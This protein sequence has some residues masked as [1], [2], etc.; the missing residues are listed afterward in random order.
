MSLRKKLIRLAHSQPELRKDL[1]PLLKQSGINNRTIIW[2]YYGVGYED[3]IEYRDDIL[4]KSFKTYQDAFM[5]LLPLKR[6]AKKK[7]FDGRGIRFQRKGQ[8]NMQAIVQADNGT[9]ELFYH[10]EIKF[11]GFEKEEMQEMINTVSKW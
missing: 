3:E 7:G 11:V 4:M 1:L 5:A 9:D 10:H 8:N 6:E 2:E